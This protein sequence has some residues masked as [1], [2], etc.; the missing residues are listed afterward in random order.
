VKIRKGRRTIIKPVTI[1]NKCV[2][3]YHKIL[4]AEDN[5]VNQTLA[6]GARFA[7]KLCASAKQLQ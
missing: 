5:R 1:I 2:F 4:A 6:G 7:A 3:Y